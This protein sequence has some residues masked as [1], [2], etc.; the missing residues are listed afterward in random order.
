MNL[1]DEYY[2][3]YLFYG[4]R[5]LMVWLRKEGYE[6]NFKRVKWL[7]RKMGLYVIYLKFWLSKGGEGYK[8]Y[9]YLFRGLSIEYLDYVWCVD[10]MY[11]WFN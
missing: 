11:I 9:L 2:M 7:M 1:I 10:I 5:W 8:K 6:V 3:G 4:V